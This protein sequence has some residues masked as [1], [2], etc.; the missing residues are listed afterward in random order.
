M[1]DLRV[2]AG[3]GEPPTFLLLHGLG[4][5]GDVWSGLTG[6]I[7]G[8]AWVAPDLPGHGGSAPLADYT[9]AA[10]ADAVAGLVDPRGTVVVGH[11]FGGVIGL[12]LA[13]R[14]GVRAVVGLGIKVAWTADELS[15]AA[16]LAAREAPVFATREEAVRRHLKVA[17]L[18]GLTDP[19]D[20]ALDAAVVR[21]DEGWRPAFD[22]R[23]F[24]VG[25]PG[26]AALLAAAPVPVVLARG[27]HDRMVDAAQLAA[28]VPNPVTLPGLGHNAHVESPA[29]LLPLLHGRAAGRAA[30]C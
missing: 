30:G 26:V 23:A 12:H 17:G 22:P 28:L 10:V 24:G 25:E 16:A 7:G 20:P 11:S 9:F 27:E 4:A 29:A 3:G 5:T 13:G 6:A 1:T 14:P 8:S 19:A 18:D 15:R 21:V 2:R